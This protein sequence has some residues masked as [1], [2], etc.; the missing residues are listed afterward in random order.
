MLLLP[1]RDLATYGGRIQYQTCHSPIHRE[2]TTYQDHY[3]A[4]HYHKVDMLRVGP[5]LTLWIA[6]LMYHMNWK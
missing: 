2:V 6:L 4:L 3:Q 1:H 5:V